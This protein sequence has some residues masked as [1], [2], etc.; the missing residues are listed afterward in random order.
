MRCSSVGQCVAQGGF[1][2]NTQSCVAYFPS[3][4]SSATT[5]CSA[6]LRW[7]SR[8]SAPCG[9]CK[10][11]PKALPLC[12][13]PCLAPS[14]LLSVSL[15]PLCPLGAGCMQVG[16]VEAAGEAQ[17]GSSAL[18]ADGTFAT[19]TMWWGPALPPTPGHV[20]WGHSPCCPP[21]S[22]GHCRTFCSLQVSPW[23]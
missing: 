17:E 4:G 11:L 10:Y 13:V 5:P 23:Q 21:W 6:S 2:A 19:V 18:T 7:P 12:S 8:A 20:G 3:A 22:P 15:C 1:L 9:C 14:L 16:R